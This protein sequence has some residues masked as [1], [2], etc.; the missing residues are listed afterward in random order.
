MNTI[1]VQRAKRILDFE[2]RALN[3]GQWQRDEVAE[4]VRPLRDQA[5]AEEGHFG[6]AAILELSRGRGGTSE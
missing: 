3:I 5:V 1:G 6:R 2:N 4:A